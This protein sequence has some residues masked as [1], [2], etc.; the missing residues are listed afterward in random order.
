MCEGQAVYRVGE[1]PA[2]LCLGLTTHSTITSA[3][4]CF[5]T[6]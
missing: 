1:G 6:A 5:L 3:F 4:L 2:T